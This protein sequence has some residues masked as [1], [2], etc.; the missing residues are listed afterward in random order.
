MA[1]DRRDFVTRASALAAMGMVSAPVLA[2]AEAG[3]DPIA[4]WIVVNAL[5]GLG[6]PNSPPDGTRSGL[7]SLTIL[8][9][10]Y[11]PPASK[12]VREYGETNATQP[13]SLCRWR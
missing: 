11:K 13:W 1:I 3:G 5:G 10:V 2:A 9:P 12:T 4:D 8:P 7:D 6:D